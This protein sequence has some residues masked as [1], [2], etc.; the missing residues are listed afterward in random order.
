MQQNRFTNLSS[1]C[2]EI[3]NKIDTESI[4]NKFPLTKKNVIV[5]ILNMIII[6]IIY[7]I[8]IMS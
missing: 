6:I 3:V 2:I 7:S 1:K 8:D 5:I 4:L